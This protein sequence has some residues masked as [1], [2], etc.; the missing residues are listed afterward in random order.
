MGSP[1]VSFT[2]FHDIPATFTSSSLDCFGFCCFWPA[3]PD[4]TASIY[5]SCPSGRRFVSSFLRTSPYDNALAPVDSRLMQSTSVG[6]FH[7]L[8]SEHAERTKNIN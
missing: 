3:N 7:S 6:D 2:H 5:G 4:D 1:Q 8:V